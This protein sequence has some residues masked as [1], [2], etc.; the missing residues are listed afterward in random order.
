[1]QEYQ[2][3]SVSRG[4]PH[5]LGMTCF[6]VPIGLVVACEQQVGSVDSANPAMGFR[7][8]QLGPLVNYTSS[9]QRSLRHILKSTTPYFSTLII[10]KNSIVK[11]SGVQFAS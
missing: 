1:M 9:S 3:K 6:S 5:I 8:Q 10:Y 11:S 7:A 2:P 4:V